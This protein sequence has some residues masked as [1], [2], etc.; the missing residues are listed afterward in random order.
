VYVLLLTHALSHLIHILHSLLLLLLT[1]AEFA[2]VCKPV[3][4]ALAPLRN[5][6]LENTP[7]LE[8][9]EAMAL[10]YYKRLSAAVGPEK[11]TN[12]TSESAVTD[13]VKQNGYSKRS[14]I[15]LMG[16]A[17]GEHLAALALCC[18]VHVC[19]VPALK[20]NSQR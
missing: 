4:L 1:A 8:P 15:P 19:L 18:V 7:G 17:I 6:L 2:S 9:A 16:P 3:F 11:I 10:A 12:F 5:D 13:Y 20:Y 14:D